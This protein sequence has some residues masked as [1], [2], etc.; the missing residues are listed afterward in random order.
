MNYFYT[1]RNNVTNKEKQSFILNVKNGTKQNIYRCLL[2]RKRESYFRRLFEGFEYELD[3]IEEVRNFLPEQYKIYANNLKLL[4]IKLISY[5]LIIIKYE[6]IEIKI[7]SK[8]LGCVY[9]S[10]GQRSHM[11]Y[12]HGCLL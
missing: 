7:A 3:N 12:P 1:Y 9:D 4:K 5:R 10:P 8:C 11:I 6:I 2:R